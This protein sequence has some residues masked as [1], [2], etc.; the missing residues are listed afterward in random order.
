[1]GRCQYR[2]TVG[3][4]LPTIHIGNACV[5]VN[6]PENNQKTGRTDPLQPN[7]EKRPQK[8][9]KRKSGDVVRSQT[10]HETIHGREG[11]RGFKGGGGTDPTPAIP[12]TGNLHWE[13]EFP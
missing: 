6:N 8:K 5:S 9:E 2:R 11:S 12:G 10:D 1:M 7:V 3:S 13:D 4:P